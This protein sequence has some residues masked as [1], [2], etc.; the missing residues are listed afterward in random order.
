M[1]FCE[2][3]VY[4]IQSGNAIS[5]IKSNRKINLERKAARKIAGCFGIEAW[6]FNQHHLE[7][8]QAD[9]DK[10]RSMFGDS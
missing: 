8:Y 2:G 5:R 9:I 6:N 10:L 3:E 7:P 4:F 1:L